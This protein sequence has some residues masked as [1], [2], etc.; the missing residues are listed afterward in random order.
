[1]VLLYNRMDCCQDR[2]NGAEVWAGNHMCGRIM[3]RPNKQTYSVPCNGV[4]AKEVS[5]K[6]STGNYLSLAEV[7]VFGKFQVFL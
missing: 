3:Y 7:Q 2:L 5:V 1:M 4:K 6:L